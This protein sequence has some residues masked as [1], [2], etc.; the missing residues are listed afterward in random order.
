MKIDRKNQ[1]ISHVS[2]FT[3]KIPKWDERRKG[4]FRLYLRDPVFIRDDPVLV[5]Y[6]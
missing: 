5:L 1:F 2:V 3:E 4:V 6:L